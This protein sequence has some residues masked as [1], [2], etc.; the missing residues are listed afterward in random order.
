[1][2]NFRPHET[3]FRT[4]ELIKELEKLPLV[5]CGCGALGAHYA[6]AMARM[7]VYS[8]FLLDMDHV[9]SVNLG[10]Q[11]YGESDVGYSKVSALNMHLDDASGDTD[12]LN[13][14]IQQSDITA[15][16]KTLWEIFPVGWS[17]TGLVIDTFDNQEARQEIQRIARFMDMDCL[18]L[19]M[20]EDFG[21]VIWDER[22]SVPVNI[23]DLPDNC[24]HPFSLSLVYRITSA[25]IEAT[26]EY[27]QGL[28]VDYRIRGM[29]IERYG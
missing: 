9:D 28:K 25:A 11:P 26:F 2:A 3:Q 14:T 17:K 1:M 12:G 27:L 8:F 7:G 24:A 13:V 6:I 29:E 21:S 22:Y 18:H 15:P 23:P 4:P 10:S 16:D 19:G 20:I 5:I